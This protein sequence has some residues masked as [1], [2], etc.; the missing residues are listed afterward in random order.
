VLLDDSRSALVDV[1]HNELAKLRQ[2]SACPELLGEG[3]RKC[4][5]TYARIVKLLERAVKPEEHEEESWTPGRIEAVLGGR[6]EGVPVVRE[7]SE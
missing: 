3:E 4:L 2:L 1:L 5:E 6:T 7:G